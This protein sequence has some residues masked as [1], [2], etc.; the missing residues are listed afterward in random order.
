ML[1]CFIINY[2]CFMCVLCVVFEFLFCDWNYAVL[3]FVH[4]CYIW[5]ICLKTI[6]YFLK[7]ALLN[8]LFL[9]LFHGF[10][11]LL[12]FVLLLICTIAS[13]IVADCDVASLL[14]AFFVFQ[15]G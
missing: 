11:I 14:R 8:F 5:C 3:H 2:M 9:N 15:F 13:C 12:Y 4:L 10:L 7:L 1:L 6:L